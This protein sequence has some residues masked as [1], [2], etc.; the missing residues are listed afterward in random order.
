MTLKREDLRQVAIVLNCLET[1]KCDQLLDQLSPENQQTIR[2]ELLELTSIS[3]QE[4]SA[5][6][7]AFFNRGP[8]DQQKNYPQSIS[9]ESTPSTED[10]VRLEISE[11]SQQI[12]QSKITLLSMSFKFRFLV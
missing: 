7:E 12:D 10:D 6:I 2:D 5:A 8:F 1:S 11:E 9:S 4:E 3:E